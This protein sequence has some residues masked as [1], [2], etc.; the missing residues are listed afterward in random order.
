VDLS[1]NGTSMNDMQL[2][3]EMD[4]IVQ[5]NLLGTMNEEM[6]AMREEMCA[7]TKQLGQLK[8]MLKSMGYQS[9]NPLP[10]THKKLAARKSSAA[11]VAAALHPQVNFL[12]TQMET[13]QKILKLNGIYGLPPKQPIHNSPLRAGIGSLCKYNFDRKDYLNQE[14]KQNEIL[15]T[16]TK[17]TEKMERKPGEDANVTGKT[18]AKPALGALPVGTY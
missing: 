15:A 6:C 1:K 3:Y 8:E 2:K 11:A 7:M 13:L 9:P 4:Q 16:F 17:P 18:I 5:K 10:A 12:S 14:T